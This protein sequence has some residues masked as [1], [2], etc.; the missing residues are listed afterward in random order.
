MSAEIW[1]AEHYA[2]YGRFVADH[3][4]PLLELLGAQPN[5]CILDLGCGDGVLTKKLADLGCKVIGLD[6]SPRLVAAARKLGLHVVESD[7]CKMDFHAEFDAVFSNG[8]LHW[9]KNAE[10]VLGRVA[11][12]LRPKG[13]FVAAM[14]GQNSIKPLLEELIGELE[15]R[16]YDGQAANPW[17]FPAPEDYAARLA[18]AGFEVDDI[19]LSPQATALPGD[20]MVWL[21]ALGGFFTSALAEDERGDYLKCVRQ[22][23]ETRVRESNAESV[24][25]SFSLTFR[26]HLSV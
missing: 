8:A 7:A 26:A 24:A 1:N 19:A 18:R 15:R 14:S 4:T 6:S 3:G 11:K 22:R 10:I 25:G 17:Y 2:K 21:T 16:G 20:A 9:M 12:A 5:E 23:L 13:R